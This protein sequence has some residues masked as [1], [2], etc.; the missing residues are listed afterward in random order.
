MYCWVF[1]TQRDVVQFHFT[2]ICDNEK[3]MQLIAGKQAAFS[4]DLNFYKQHEA[5]FLRL[6]FSSRYYCKTNL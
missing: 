3:S 1:R 6:V 2:G 5:V 4:F